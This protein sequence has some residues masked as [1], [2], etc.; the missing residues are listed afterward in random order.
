MSTTVVDARPS[1]TQRFNNAKIWHSIR[2]SAVA[3]EVIRTSKM[4]DMLGFFFAQVSFS[5]HDSVLIF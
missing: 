3:Y 4:I 5:M 1:I 2:R